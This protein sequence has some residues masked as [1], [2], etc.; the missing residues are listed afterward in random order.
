MTTEHVNPPEQASETDIATASTAVPEVSA[1]TR[2]WDTIARWT[3][4]VGGAIGFL[5]SFV[6]TV[7]KIELIIDP[8]YVPTCSINP[9]LSCGSVMDTTQASL[10]GFPN[11]L[12]GIT[13]FAVALTTAMALF[14]GGRLARWYWI[15]LQV[16]VSAAVVLIHW[17]IYTS[18]YTIGALCPYCMVVWSVIMPIF[19][20]VTVRNLHAWGVVE[21]SRV[22]AAFAANHI[23]LLTAW[24]L[25]VLAL[26]LERFWDYWVTLI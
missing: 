22:V 19:A 18:L 10:F 16:G 20:V 1:A 13:G 23:V 5:A 11:S 7:E 17:L 26:I 6:L 14:A 24:Y 3:L 25:I 2:S 4:A 8:N 21:R 15:G 12:L 9:I